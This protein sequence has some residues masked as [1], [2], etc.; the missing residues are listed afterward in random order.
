MNI[1]IVSAGIRGYLIKYFKEALAG[2]GLVFAAD[3]SKFAPAL[4][5]A[6]DY[7]IIPAV[8]DSE[9]IKTIIKVCQN[10]S[11]EGIISLSDLELPILA[12]NKDKLLT[13]G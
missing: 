13:E 9:Y 4:Y 2:R 6:D 7:F 12:E 3:C 8:T 5:D 11:I 1:L 10:N